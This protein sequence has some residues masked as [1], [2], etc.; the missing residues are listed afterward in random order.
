MSWRPAHGSGL[1][2]LKRERQTQRYPC[3]HVDPQQLDRRN[4]KGESDNYCDEQGG[5]LPAVSRQ[6]H[7]DNFLQVIVDGTAFPNRSDDRCEIVVDKDYLGCGLGRLGPF[8]THGDADIGLL[9][10]GRVVY[11]VAGHRDHVALALQRLH[12]SKLVGR[13]CASE[14]RYPVHHGDE[15]FIGQQ[16]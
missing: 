8:A 15:A 14:H 11:A 5:C 2:G 1:G 7:G 4:R 16:L 3:R 9:Q 6:H 10:S 12:Q 13:T